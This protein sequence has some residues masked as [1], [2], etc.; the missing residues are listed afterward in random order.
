MLQS[1]V[2]MA[3]RAL[4]LGD[5]EQDIMET[6]WDCSPMTVR[7]VVD[8][9]QTKRQS[10][11]TTVMTVMNRLVEKGMLRRRSHG[12]SYVYAPTKPREAYMA[13]ASRQVIDDLIQSYGSVAIAQFLDRLDISDPELLR[14]LKQRF[15]LPR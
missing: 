12:A 5:L 7:D 13:Q 14:K 4:H 9:L 15:S 1:V 8:Q 11:Y 10:A 6:V 2:A 3:H